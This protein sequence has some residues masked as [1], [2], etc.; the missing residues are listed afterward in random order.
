MLKVNEE[1]KTTGGRQ[2][3]R[4]S[5]VIMMVRRRSRAK[6]N[7]NTY[8]KNE[9]PREKGGLENEWIKMAFEPVTH[10]R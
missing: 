7:K 3:G 8:T 9:N 2:R 4:L 10:L 1:E 5:K 6:A